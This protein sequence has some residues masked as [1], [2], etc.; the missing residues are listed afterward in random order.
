MMTT[1]HPKPTQDQYQEIIKCIRDPMYFIEKYY[2]II[3]PVNG[4]M[5]YQII[6]EHREIADSVIKGN[7]TVVLAP[8]QH[9]KTTIIMGLM[10]WHLCF[11]QYKTICFSSSTHTHASRILLELKS[12][13][14]ALPL[15][16]KPY[17]LISNSF[18]LI[19]SNDVHIKTLSLGSQ[20]QNWPGNE[21][22]IVWV[23]DLQ[24]MNKEKL[25]KLFK[26]GTFQNYLLNGPQTI[27]TSSA[28]EFGSMFQWIW[29]D[30][31]SGRNRFTPIEIELNSKFVDLKRQSELERSVGAANF[32]MEFKNKFL[33]THD[34]IQ[35]QTGFIKRD[36]ELRDL[37]KWFN[38]KRE[39]REG[40]FEKIFR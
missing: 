19:A 2:H 15:W 35:N 7:D 14:E 23:E 28:G 11:D 39:Y 27:L 6:D 25:I 5:K 3:S 1:Q 9:G 38:I 32:Q 17:L 29:E 13:Y 10:L 30:A 40:K 18:E 31:Q 20:F 24:Y 4:S 16:I 21:Y 26:D 33:M 22:D 8:R 37:W 12:K 34:V 36:P